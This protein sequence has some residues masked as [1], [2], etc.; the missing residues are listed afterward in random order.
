MGALIIPILVDETEDQRSMTYLSHLAKEWQSRA[1]QFSLCRSL[2]SFI[3]NMASSAL[4]NAPFNLLFLYSAFQIL[5]VMNGL[6]QRHFI[7]R[8]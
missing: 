3:Q 6:W 2:G 7:L 8:E 1:R 5:A 4:F